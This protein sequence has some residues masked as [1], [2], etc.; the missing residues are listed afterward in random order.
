MIEDILR[1][2]NITSFSRELCKISGATGIFLSLLFFA[3]AFAKAS[4]STGICGIGIS[5]A[6]AIA[7]ATLIALETIATNSKRQPVLIALQTWTTEPIDL[8]NEKLATHTI[9]SPR[10]TYCC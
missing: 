9:S 8:I 1:A 7:K 5:L 2:K 4:L 6:L 10:F 3:Y